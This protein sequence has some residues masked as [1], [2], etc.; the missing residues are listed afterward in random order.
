MKW[1]TS[2][3]ITLSYSKSISKC[4]LIASGNCKSFEIIFQELLNWLNSCSGTSVW[5]TQNATYKKFW[6]ILLF[7]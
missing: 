2:N 5:S 3:L 1:Q 7:N 6:I 4:L